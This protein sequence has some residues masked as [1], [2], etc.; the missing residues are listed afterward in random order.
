MEQEEGRGG[1]CGIESCYAAKI[2]FDRDARQRD[3]MHVG[4]HLTCNWFTDD[5]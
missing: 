3:E 4:S 5:E 1:I 2:G